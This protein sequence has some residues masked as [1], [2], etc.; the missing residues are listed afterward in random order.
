MG[1]TALEEPEPEPRARAQAR[2]P[3]LCARNGFRVTGKPPSGAAAQEGVRGIWKL[4]I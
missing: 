4:G 1:G 2:A 3:F